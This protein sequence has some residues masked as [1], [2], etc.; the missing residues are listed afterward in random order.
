MWIMDPR[1]TGDVGN[2]SQ[3]NRRCG[4]WI[5]EKQEMWVMDPRKTGDVDNGSQK[6]RSCG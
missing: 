4:E 3:E 2:G 1:K 6:N 5:L